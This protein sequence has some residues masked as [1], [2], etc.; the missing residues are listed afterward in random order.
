MGDAP[1]DLAPIRGTDDTLNTL[2]FIR[3]RHPL[4]LDMIPSNSAW[5]QAA[6][7][8]VTC[9]SMCAGGARRHLSPGTDCGDLSVESGGRAT[10]AG[11]VACG[12][13]VMGCVYCCSLWMALW[14]CDVS[15][16]QGARGVQE[17]ADR[18]PST[19]GACHVI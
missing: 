19:D 1:V 7:A 15:C 6:A 11:G 18:G 9:G 17:G 2:V 10:G 5:S 4:A 3:C 12:A 13:G 8:S 14:L 16:L